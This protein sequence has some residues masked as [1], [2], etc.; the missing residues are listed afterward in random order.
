[1]KNFYCPD[2]YNG[3]ETYETYIRL[4]GMA[5]YAFIDNFSIK[6]IFGSF[7]S[8]IWNGG[9]IITGVQD[10]GYVKNLIQRY[11]NLNIPLHL[12]LTNPSLTKEDC[13]D[14]WC[15]AVLKE[16]YNGINKV[17]ISSPYL[18]EY[19]RKNYPD[20][21]IIKSIITTE[22]DRDY[23]KD[24]NEYDM[25]VL[26]RRLVKNFDY[27]NSIPEDKRNRFELL[28]ND[29]CPISC[30]FLYNHYKEYAKVTLYET[31]IKTAEKEQRI[32]C[33]TL[34][35]NPFPARVAQKDQI[36]PKE[37]NSYEDLGFTE[38]K[39]SGR[40]KKLIPPFATVPF[41]IKEEYQ[42]EI[43]KHLMASLYYNI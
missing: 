39:I 13:Y 26:P 37:L 7:P 16:C 42:F 5:P 34:Q 22:E 30:P 33:K 3:I 32:Q 29:P 14:R 12:T 1:M 35:N 38:F 18:E 20:Y 41:L 31:D 2:I 23:V 25:V 28:C 10:L 17:I 9:T 36:L 4:Y 19:I 8:M 27:L 15:N 11:S 24:L 40:G 21:K 6:A 43:L